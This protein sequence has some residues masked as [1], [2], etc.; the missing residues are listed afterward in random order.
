MNSLALCMIVRDACASLAACLASVH[1]IVQEV[2]IGD[3]GS[4]DGT[5]EIARRFGARVL[6]IPWSDDFSA[7]RNRVLAEASCDWILSLDADEQLDAEAGRQIPVLLANTQCAGF[8]V[9]IRNYVLNM[10]EHAG[11]QLP[12]PNDSLLPCTVHYP[13]YIE[14]ENFRLFR[15][16]PKIQF[17]G[18]LL[19]KRGPAYPSDGSAFGQGQL[20]HSSFRPGHGRIQQTA[21]EHALS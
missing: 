17:E 15:H 6:E 5:I 1:G 19:R 10:G 20:P 16:D 9:I 3:T 8:Q 12:K 13:G 7:A 11:E 21:K 2:L 14:C 18:R 4:T